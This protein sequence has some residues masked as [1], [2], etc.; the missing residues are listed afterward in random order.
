MNILILEDEITTQRL[1]LYLLKQRFPDCIVD[2]SSSITR[3]VEL[4]ESKVYDVVFADYYLDD[5]TALEIY[6]YLHSD[7]FKILMSASHSGEINEHDKTKTNEAYF[8][9]YGFDWYLNKTDLISFI[10]DGNFRKHI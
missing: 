8:I 6:S 3:A 5:G 2:T 10:D 4:V 7:T 9:D 1:V